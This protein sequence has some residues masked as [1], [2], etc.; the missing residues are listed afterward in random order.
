M[1]TPNKDN[2]RSFPATVAAVLDEYTVVINRGLIDG[3]KQGQRFLIYTL[4]SETLLDPETNEPLGRLEIVKGTGTVI[5][6]QEKMST[7]RS[8][9]QGQSERKVVR[10]NSP[11]IG[12]LGSAEEETIY[13]PGAPLSFDNPRSGDLAKPI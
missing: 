7:I 13:V 8:E 3:V 9:K 12:M 10:R 1:Q 4:A 11:W 2:A 6:A 5:H